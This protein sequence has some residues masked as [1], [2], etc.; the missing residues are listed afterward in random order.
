MKVAI[1]GATLNAGVM[2]T[3][4]SE[5]GN[6]VYWCSHQNNES[7]TSKHIQY[8]DE[9]VNFRLD[10]QYKLGQLLYS[11][12]ADLPSNVD[13]YFFCYSPTESELA[14][15]TL[16]ALAL[17]PIVHPKLMINAA[18]FGLNGTEKLKAI[19]PKDHWVYLPDVI[20]EGNAINS[21]LHLK[22]I[23]VGVGEKQLKLWLKNYYDQYLAR[24]INIYLCPFLMQNLPN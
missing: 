5:Y 12:L 9:E 17:K 13:V 2:A 16:K 20:Q 6:Q 7:S 15:Q 3:L 19:S 24:L 8:L 1:L 18:T 11:S 21:I 4:L 10:K 22:H 23:I 14:D